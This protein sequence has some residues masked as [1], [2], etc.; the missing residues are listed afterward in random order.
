MLEIIDEPRSVIERDDAAPAPRRLPVVSWIVLKVAQRCNLNCT[1]CYVYNRGDD[2]WR[3]RPKLLSPAV[4]AQLAVRIKAHAEAY[5]LEEFMVELHGG[6]A[7][8]LGKRRMREMLDIL[9]AGCEGVNLR[10]IMQTNG[11]LLDVAWLELLDEYGVKF[12]IS[13]DG[14]PEIADRQRVYLNGRGSTRDLLD[15][16]AALRAAT[17]LFDKLFS[18]G[19][20]VINAETSGEEMVRWMMAQGLKS[21]DFLLPDASYDNLPDD[22]PGVGV[23]RRFLIEAFDYWL[24]LGEN[25]PQIRLFELMMMGLMGRKPALDAL[26]GELRAICVVETNGAIGVLDTLR[27][28]GDLYASD[29]LNVFDHGL[30]VHAAHYGIDQI[31]EP[32]DQCKACPYF[33]ACGGGYLPHRY[34]G[35]SFANPSLYCEALAGLSERMVELLRRELPESMWR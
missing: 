1:Y 7:L 23:Y 30:D 33:Q 6:E 31:Q 13:F 16:V 3:S 35:E 19:L 24:S 18:G 17:P 20:C 4:A 25:A 27:I 28:C 14:P 12:G 15:K 26:G 10:F 11:L 29:Q 32:C 5:G 34:D 22:W 9:K 21:F 2:T 8:L